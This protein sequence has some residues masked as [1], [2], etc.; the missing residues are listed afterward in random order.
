LVQ[1]VPDFSAHIVGSLKVLVN[2]ERLYVDGG[3]LVLKISA[4]NVDLH[5]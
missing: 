2:L 1:N 4:K 5:G 3:E